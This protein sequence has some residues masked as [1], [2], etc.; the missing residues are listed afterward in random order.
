MFGS[1]VCF[2]FTLIHPAL[3]NGVLNPPGTAQH[4]AWLITSCFDLN[5]VIPHK[6]HWSLP[7][8]PGN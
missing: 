2:I 4:P 5:A 7:V 6:H 8:L 1:S 3:N